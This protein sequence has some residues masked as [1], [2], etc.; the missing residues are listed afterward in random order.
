MIQELLELTK[1]T[2]LKTFTDSF[3]LN[4]GM[5]FLFDKDGNL[6]EK[7]LKNNKEVDIWES[8]FKEKLFFSTNITSNKAFYLII[9]KFKA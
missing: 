1:N 6:I 4:N 3:L 5:Y 8:K 7:H 2:S 9:E